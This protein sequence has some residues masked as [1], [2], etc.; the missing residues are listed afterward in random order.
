MKRD[1]EN[2]SRHSQDIVFECDADEK[3]CFLLEY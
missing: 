1:I 3:W 2:I